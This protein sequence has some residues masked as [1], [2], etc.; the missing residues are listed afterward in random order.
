MEIYLIIFFLSAFLIA[1]AQSKEEDDKVLFYGLSI[2]AVALPVL[3]AAFRDLGIGTDTLGYC[4]RVWGEVLR[5]RRINLL[6]Y[7]YYNEYFQDVD[8]FYLVLNWFVSLFT[9]NI[10]VLLFVFNFIVVGLVY[11]V[12]YD[13]RDKAAMWQV[14]LFFY[15]LGYNNSLNLMRQYIAI[16]IGLYA[17]KYL[18]NKKWFPL[19]ICF[20]IMHFCHGSSIIYPALIGIYLFFQTKNK[21]VQWFVP[22][23]IITIAYLI[24]QYFDNILL[25]IIE[26][27]FMQDRFRAYLSENSE[28]TFFDTSSSLLAIIMIVFFIYVAIINQDERAEL[29]K[30]IQFKS[31]AALFNLTSTISMYAL[32]MSFYFAT[33]TDCLFLPKALQMVKEKK[34]KSLYYMLS[35]LFVILNT[36]VWYMLYVKNGI[37]QTVPYRSRILGI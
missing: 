13:Y 17:F 11:K 28:A 21:Y 20:F 30:F 14:M 25:F 6:L 15:L 35:A 12:A 9:D 10:H 31:V 29:K 23:G 18:E 27:G 5:V 34:S 37:N 4:N 1:I 33:I 2:V 36:V 7:M 16:V 32:R 26:N 24:F 8:L 19:A 22:V 3:L